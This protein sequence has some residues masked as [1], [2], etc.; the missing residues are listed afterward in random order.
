MGF[1]R[2]IQI[3]LC[4]IY[5]ISLNETNTHFTPLNLTSH[6]ACRLPS[7]PKHAGLDSCVF[8]TLPNIRIVT[9]FPAP[10][11]VADINNENGAH[12]VSN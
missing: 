2:V 5:A 1:G 10:G 4:Q 8:D 3:L 11:T 6:R 12:C 9:T 7:C